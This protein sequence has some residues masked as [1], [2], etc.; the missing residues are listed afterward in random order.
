[1]KRCWAAAS[2]TGILKG[3]GDSGVIFASRVKA[4]ELGYGRVNRLH[5]GGS[6]G[7]VV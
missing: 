2:R 1:M 3:V 6:T 4:R 5:G 7:F